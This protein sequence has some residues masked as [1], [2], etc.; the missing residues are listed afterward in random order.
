MLENTPTAGSVKINGSNLGSS[1]AGTIP[2]TRISANTSTGFSIVEFVGNQTSG[3]TVAHGLSVAPALIYLK[4]LDTADQLDCI[5][6][7]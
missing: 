5:C 7:S 2:A 1:L 6:C 4:S 3:A